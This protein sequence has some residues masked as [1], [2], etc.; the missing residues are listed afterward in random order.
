MTEERKLIWVYKRTADSNWK[1]RARVS[2]GRRPRICDNS[3]QPEEGV[4]RIQT[5]TEVRHEVKK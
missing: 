5:V 1:S 4:R 2:Q 3:G